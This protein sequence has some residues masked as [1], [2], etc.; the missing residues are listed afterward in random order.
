MTVPAGKIYDY[1]VD[2]NAIAPY[3][4]LE[5]ELTDKLTLGTGLRYD[6]NSFEY[7]N[8]VGDGVYAT[9]TFAR[10]SSDRDPT[11]N[12]LS[13]KVDLT[14]QM[15][16]MQ[17][18]YARYANGFRIPQATRLYQLHQQTV[19]FTIDEETTD[20]YEIGY[21][22]KTD[23]N[24]FSAAL[25]YLTIE[26]TIVERRTGAFPNQTRFYVNGDRTIHRGIELS[27]ASQWTNEW[28]TKV[29]YS[30]S[31]HEFDNDAQNGDNE[32]REAPENIANAR[33]IYSPKALPGLMTMLEWEHVGSYWLD[34]AN[35]TRY[36]GHDVANLKM[37]Y[38]I[39]DNV[40]IFGRVNNLTDRLYAE[41]ANITFGPAQRYTPAEPRQAF[42]GVEYKM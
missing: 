33:V 1:E 5:F 26:D 31:Q 2:Y 37:R 12:H 39:N 14:Y 16:E 22:L 18:V 41:T 34:D 21:K 4:R 15:D 36:A 40:T 35:T 29:A 42:F 32:Q 20:T 19:D 6:Y 30:F 7:T 25:Y 23:Q 27:W 28:T 13:P 24:E 8:K 17:T 10:A 11:F 3:A 9:S 38:E